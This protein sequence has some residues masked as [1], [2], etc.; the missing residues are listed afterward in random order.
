MFSAGIHF[1]AENCP[2]LI[3]L[4]LDL[5]KLCFFQIIFFMI[6]IPKS[7]LKKVKVFKF[8]LK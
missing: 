4:L 7:N 2:K 6:V 8:G 1:K 5:L 3:V